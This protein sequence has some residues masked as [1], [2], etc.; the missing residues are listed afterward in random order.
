MTAIGPLPVF[1]QTE[2][3]DSIAS[4]LLSEIIGT[5]HRGGFEG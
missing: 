1:D 2:N 5:A 4:A 3:D